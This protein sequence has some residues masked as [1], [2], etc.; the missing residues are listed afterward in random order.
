[1]G[2][3]PPVFDLGVNLDGQNRQSVLDKREQW[4]SPPAAFS[5]GVTLCFALAEHTPG[6]PDCT[7]APVYPEAS[8][9]RRRPQL[10]RRGRWLLGGPA[11][12]KRGLFVNLSSGSFPYDLS[13]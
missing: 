9:R 8:S 2:T 7:L 5:A 12:R 10:T 1:M 13:S 6:V 4:E 3:Y 11:A